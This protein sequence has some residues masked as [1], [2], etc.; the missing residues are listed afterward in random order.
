MNA[1]CIPRKNCPPPKIWMLQLM[2]LAISCLV[3]QENFVSSIFRVTFPAPVHSFQG[4]LKFHS[5]Q[6]LLLCSYV[7]RY[8][9]N[10]LTIIFRGLREKIHKLNSC[11]DSNVLG[12]CDAYQVFRK[13]QLV[14]PLCQS[15]VNMGCVHKTFF[16]PDLGTWN[17]HQN[18]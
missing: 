4:F 9:S 14:A 15:G 12:A 17:T 8:F 18:C 3:F 6:E 11:G 1:L 13:F 10:N 7:G 16:K 2:C 5:F